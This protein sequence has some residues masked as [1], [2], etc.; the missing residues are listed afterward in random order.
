MHSPVEM[1]RNRLDDAR[2]EKTFV[3]PLRKTLVTI[4]VGAVHENDPG[5]EFL[6]RFLDW[7]KPLL[8]DPRTQHALH[9][10]FCTRRLQEMQNE[11]GLNDTSSRLLGTARLYLRKYIGS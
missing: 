1:I 7:R 10:P 6:H 5:E 11:A 2:F 3:R 4:P 8:S 9:C